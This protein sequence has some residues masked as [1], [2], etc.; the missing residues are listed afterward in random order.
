MNSHVRKNKYLRI[1]TQ[2]KTSSRRKN[3]I[4]KTFIRKKTQIN[5]QTIQPSEEVTSAIAQ[6]YQK[7]DIPLS[8]EQTG[9]PSAAQVRRTAVQKRFRL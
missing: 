2:T 8:I 6:I 4:I 5:S 7:Y 1:L 9:E 3:S